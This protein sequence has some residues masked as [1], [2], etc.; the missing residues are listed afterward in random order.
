MQEDFELFENLDEELNDQTEMQ[1]GG[2][3]DKDRRDV[4]NVPEA[5]GASSSFTGT[6]RKSIALVFSFLED[7]I[8]CFTWVGHPIETNLDASELEMA[9]EIAILKRLSSLAC[10]NV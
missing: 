1:D 8:R 7:L 10:H 2:N 3:D 6:Y 4:D 5:E 9:S